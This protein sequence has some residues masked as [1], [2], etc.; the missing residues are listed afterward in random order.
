MPTQV[1]RRFYARLRRGDLAGLCELLGY[2]PATGSILC[3]EAVLARLER[4]LNAM[5]TTVD[6]A[7]ARCLDR[8]VPLLE[9][10]S[11]ALDRQGDVLA[12]GRYRVANKFMQKVVETP[13]VHRWRV[14]N[15]AIVGLTSYSGVTLALLPAKTDR[16]VEGAADEP[17]DLRS[18]G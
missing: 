11:V 9:I 7:G 12:L 2:G 15:G 18:P 14:E 5:G 4:I 17:H 1:V 13:V 16:A 8:S 6:A 10:V 3:N